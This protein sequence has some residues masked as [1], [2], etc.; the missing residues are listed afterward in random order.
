MLTCVQPADPC[1]RLIGSSAALW[2]QEVPYLAHHRNSDGSHQELR[3]E[4]A[5]HPRI[6][7][8]LLTNIHC[9]GIV[10]IMEFTDSA[11]HYSSRKVKGCLYFQRLR[12]LRTPVAPN[13]LQKLLVEQIAWTCTYGDREICGLHRVDTVHEAR[14]RCMEPVY[15]GGPTFLRPVF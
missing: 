4:V 5:H 3:R 7:T 13:R 12:G 2:P 15:C 10:P 8:D 14:N 11:V 9:R 1:L 6:D